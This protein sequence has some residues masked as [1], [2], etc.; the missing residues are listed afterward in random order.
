MHVR[1]PC[2]ATLCIQL[3]SSA[4]QGVLC[5]EVCPPF[6]DMLHMAVSGAGGNRRQ[7]SDG[8][9]DRSRRASWNRGTENGCMGPGW[10]AHGGIHRGG[11]TCFGS[12]T[13]CYEICRLGH[14]AICIADSWVD[15]NGASS[16]LTLPTGA[17]GTGGGTGARRS[18]PP[19]ISGSC[20]FPGAAARP[21]VL[22]S[23]FLSPLHP[24]MMSCLRAN[25]YGS[26][27]LPSHGE[28]TPDSE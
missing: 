4:Q 7:M 25:N 10:L 24:S 18:V 11:A 20:G 14:C 17:A 5:S 22:V 12:C 23:S 1:G 9:G 19:A 15:W 2:A 27:D 8:M 28:V 6:R 16:H 21:L 26:R 13:A 3:L